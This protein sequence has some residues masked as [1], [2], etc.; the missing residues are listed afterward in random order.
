MSV[1]TV[2]GSHSSVLITL[3]T[4]RFVAHVALL[5]CYSSILFLGAFCALECNAKPERVVF[6]LSGC[7]WAVS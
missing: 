5:L 6:P 4:P 2:V 1:L 3:W 7:T